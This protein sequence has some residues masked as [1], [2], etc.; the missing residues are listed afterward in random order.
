MCGAPWDMRG[1]WCVALITEQAGKWQS[2]DMVRFRLSLASKHVGK[3]IWT[4]R[5]IGQ[6]QTH[7]GWIDFAFV[8][9]VSLF[10]LGFCWRQQFI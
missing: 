6:R 4:P 2:A 10:R 9:F 7:A 5:L 8:A 1:V 3:Q